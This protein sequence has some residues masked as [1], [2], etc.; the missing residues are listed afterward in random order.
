MGTGRLI[1]P[2]ISQLAL[3]IHLIY[4]LFATALLGAPPRQPTL[5]LAPCGPYRIAGNQILDRLNRPWLARG[6]RLAAFKLQSTAVERVSGTFGPW[7]AT[8]LTTIRQ[9]LNM[10]TVRI[11][12]NPE[13]FN[14]NPD[15]QFALKRLL[16][17]ARRVELLVILD[18]GEKQWPEDSLAHFWRGAA[19]QYKDDPD[20]F[21]AVGHARFIQTIRQLGARQPLIVRNLERSEVA[22]RDVIF[23][24]SPA[25]SEIRKDGD[26]RARYGEAAALRPMLVSGLDP[27]F[28]SKSNECAAFPAEPTEASSF[29]EDTLSFFDQ[30]SVSWIVSSFEPGRLITGYRWYDGTKLDSG[31][32]CGNASNGTGLGMLLLAH[33]WSTTPL[34]LLTVS[35]SRGGF[36]IARGGIAHSYGPILADADVFARGGVLPTH[37]SNVSVRISGSHGVIRHA[38]L[39]YTNAGWSSLSFVMPDEVAAGPADVDIVRSDGSIARSKVLIADIAPAMFT[40]PPDGRSV[41][42]AVVTQR[43]AGGLA[44]SFDAWNCTQPMAC[45]STPIRLSPRVTT[46]LRFMGTGFRHAQPGAEFHVFA[47][48]TDLP[49]LSWGASPLPGSDQVTVRVPDSLAGSG[50]TD[51]YCT[52]NGELSNVVRVN[53]GARN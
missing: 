19:S 37:M 35:E 10:N 50:E 49:V 45:D 12:A 27:E 5:T 20:V 39:L 13:D 2:L 9:R 44:H 53:F 47:N 24:D 33:L 4:L 38:R 40:H 18:A 8:T 21:F 28:G 16:L 25:F 48:G 22:D 32:E 1:R 34:A 17:L 23:E 30:M 51:V 41:A 42:D 3:K 26:R 15:Y 7:S 6:T 52:V 36:V 14:T 29:I 11:S 43:V 46:T 31:W